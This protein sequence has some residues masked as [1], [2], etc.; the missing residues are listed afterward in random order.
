MARFWTLAVTAAV[1]IALAAWWVPPEVGGGDGCPGGGACAEETHGPGGS[2]GPDWFYGGEGRIRADER[3]HSREETGGGDTNRC[4]PSR[5]DAPTAA[6]EE[7]PRG[8]EDV[9]VRF[10]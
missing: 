5:Y 4:S 3:P 10:Y 2:G 1:V 8:C 6:G 7:L 9:R